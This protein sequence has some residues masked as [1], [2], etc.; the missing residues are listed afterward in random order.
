[1][2]YQC[3][4]QPPCPASG[5]SYF[6][7]I[8]VKE[9]YMSSWYG[10]PSITLFVRSVSFYLVTLNVGY[11]RDKIS[12]F[13]KLLNYESVHSRQMRNRWPPADFY[14]RV[15]NAELHSRS[16]ICSSQ[17]L[18]SLQSTVIVSLFLFLSLFLSRNSLYA[19]LFRRDADARIY[20]TVNNNTTDHWS[21]IV[22]FRLQ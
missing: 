12:A 6:I 19:L 22:F 3:I 14:L 8:V 10:I 17:F 1:M 5:K 20:I 7:I 16:C 9:S 13:T 15:K 18:T 11:T 2:T 4:R 21:A